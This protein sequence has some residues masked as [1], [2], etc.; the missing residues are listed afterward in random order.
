[1]WFN[2]ENKL[3]T[4]AAS[5]ERLTWAEAGAYDQ[6]YEI[7]Q[8]LPKGLRDHSRIGALLI[9]EMKGTEGKNCWMAPVEGHKK[10]LGPNNHV[11]LLEKTGEEFFDG[12][13]ADTTYEMVEKRLE[14]YIWLEPR[15]EA[16]KEELSL[17]T[18]IKGMYRL[19]RHKLFG[20]KPN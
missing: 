15:K 3:E 1:M 16:S 6:F 18:R 20:K 9:A 19:A 4:L 11:K 7:E 14:F 13:W 10:I 17:S 2:D 5:Q 12:K 8:K